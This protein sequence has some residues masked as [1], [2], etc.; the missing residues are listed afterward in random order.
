MEEVHLFLAVPLAVPLEVH[1]SPEVLLVLLVDLEVRLE[2]RLVVLEVPSL[3]ELMLHLWDQCML[4][5]HQGL[6]TSSPSTQTPTDT[7]VKRSRTYWPLPNSHT[8]TFCKYI[9]IPHHA[10]ILT[11]H[12]F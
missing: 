2:V 12:S 5:L 9:I 7:S 8:T 11:I 4:P 10:S 6:Q 1:P 3:E